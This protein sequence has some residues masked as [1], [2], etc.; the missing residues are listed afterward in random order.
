MRAFKLSIVGE[1]HQQWPQ[2]KEESKILLKNAMEKLSL[3]AKAYDRISKVARTISDL[4]NSQHIQSKHVAEAIQYS[5]S[6]REGW[7]A[8]R[9]NFCSS[10][11]RHYRSNQTELIIHQ[12]E[13]IS[14]RFLQT[15]KLRL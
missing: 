7:L 11:N 2:L 1:K 10:L 13:S 6:D 5:S 9:I 12:K 8:Y 14:Y 3:S 15:K 4:D